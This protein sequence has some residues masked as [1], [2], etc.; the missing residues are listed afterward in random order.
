MRNSRKEDR[1]SKDIVEKN[2]TERVRLPESR[3][4]RTRSH[5]TRL[6]SDWRLTSNHGPQNHRVGLAVTRVL[7][8]LG[9][10]RPSQRVSLA[11]GSGSPGSQPAIYHG[12]R[13]STPG[14]CLTALTDIMT[15]V[16]GNGN[17]S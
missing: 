7:A 12:E 8:C 11:S 6:G 16:N 9:S 17:L 2:R 5:M 1:D 13:Q 14:V 15:A 4:G 3:T 10:D